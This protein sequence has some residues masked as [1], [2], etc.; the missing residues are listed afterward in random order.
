[1]LAHGAGR[2]HA[3]PEAGRHGEGAAGRDRHA[4]SAC[5]LHQVTRER[6]L[7]RCSRGS[8][9]AMNDATASG[10]AAE[11]LEPSSTQIGI[12][13]SRRE[14]DINRLLES[15]PGR[16]QEDHP[17]RRRHAVPRAPSDRSC[18]SRSCAP[19]RSAS[20]WAAPPATPIPFYPIQLLRQ[21]RQAQQHAWSRPTRRCT[22]RRSTS[23][24]PTPS[25]GFDFSGTRTSTSK[26]GYRST[27]VP[28]RADEEPRGRDHRRAAADQRQ[29]SAR[30]ARS[31]RSPTPTSAWPNRSPRRRRSRS[32]TGC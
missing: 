8:V 5:G 24:T 26:T 31:C 12:A 18:A 2:G 29:G 9:P 14:R 6:W 7:S 27:V 15:D 23:P 25:E 20:R 11:R 4:A 1:M 19:T 17:R 28:H 13:L 32:P 3:H 16:G 22:A 10:S 21:G 30:P